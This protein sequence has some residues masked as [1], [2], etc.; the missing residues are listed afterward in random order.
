MNIKDTALIH[1]ALGVS[2]PISELKQR[3][4]A[5]GDREGARIRVSGRMQARLSGSGFAITSIT[6]E[7]QAVARDEVTEWKWEVRPVNKGRHY[8]HLTL[9]VLL[10]VDSISTPR[11]IRTFDKVIEVEVTWCQRAGSFIERNWQWLWAAVLLPIAGWIWK[12]R[13]GA[14]SDESESAS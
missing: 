12:R 14:K 4:E 9:S 1:L 11:A 13:T 3:I 7:T 5:T 10:N 8:L 2:A 6:S